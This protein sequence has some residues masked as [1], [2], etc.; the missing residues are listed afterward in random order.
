MRRAAVTFFAAALVT[1]CVSD[2]NRINASRYYDAGLAL[3]AR[4]Q[5][6]Q[7]REAYWR[8]LVNYR[9]AGG[10]QNAISAATYNLGRMTGLT[11][12]FPLAEQFLLEA[13]RL[14][15]QLPTPSPGNVTKRLGELA[16]ISFALGK[17][18]L[19][20]QYYERAVPLLEEGGILQDDP[21][22]Y[23][24]YLDGYANALEK[25]SMPSKASDVRNRAS[26]LR[27]AGSNRR[28]LFVPMYYN[29]VC[30]GK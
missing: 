1:G 20:V 24:M 27:A 7:A 2:I 23:A 21:I 26:G 18:E 28:M 15:E 6:E 13:L 16:N 4:K 3:E 25:A 30:R 12:N 22:G 11:C 19:S 14:E 5:Y 10:P 17:F 9:S 8:A 29:E